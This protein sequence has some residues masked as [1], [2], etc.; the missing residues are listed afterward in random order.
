MC[1]YI[2]QAEKFL[3]DTNTTME[4]KFTGRT[5]KDWT[6]EERDHDSYSITLK[7]LYKTGGQFTHN[8]TYTFP[9][10]DSLNNTEKND[11][12][13]ITKRVLTISAHDVLACLNPYCE[14]LFDDFVSE[15]GYTWDSEEEYLKIKQIH[16]DCVDQA[17][18]LRAMYNSEELDQ[19]AEIQ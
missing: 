1:E 9:F 13:S 10:Y 2:Q 15:F 16:F 11:E 18:Q 4:V 8:K 3:T 17:R 7:R 12:L 19:L 5:K 14:E 6:G